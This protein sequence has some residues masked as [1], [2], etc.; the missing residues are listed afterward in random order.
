MKRIILDTNALMAV[1]EFKIDIFSEIETIYSFPYTFYVL[2]GTLNE[3]GRIQ[4]EQRGKFVR[5]AKL[6][7]ALLKAKKVKIIDEEGYVDELLVKYSKEGDLILTQDMA[8]KKKLQKPY[9]TI[10][11]KRRVIMVY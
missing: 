6:A 5:A 1:G 11:Q 8:L 9:F 10:R 2:Q 4:K 3:L 7:L